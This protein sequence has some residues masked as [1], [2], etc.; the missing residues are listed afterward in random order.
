M[1][2]HGNGGLGTGA[3]EPLEARTLMSL[4][5]VGIKAATASTTEGFGAAKAAIVVIDRSGGNLA[6]PLTVDF[7]L[8]GSATSGDYASISTSAVI[9]AGVKSVRIPVISTDD[10]LA[11]SSEQVSFTLAASDRYTV[12]E[13]RRAATVT[14]VDNEPIVSI[15]RGKDASEGKAG[16]QAGSFTIKRSGKDLTQSIR[17]DL[18]LQSA[19]TAT[20]GVDFVSMPRSVVIPAGQS[21]VSLP[22]TPIQDGRQEATERVWIGLANADRYRLDAKRTAAAVGIAN[23]ARYDLVSA[24]GLDRASQL[25]Y[26]YTID[27]RFTYSDAPADVART[28]GL[29]DISSSRDGSLAFEVTSSSDSDADYLLR[30]F[31][32][33]VGDGGNYLSYLD[34]EDSDLGFADCQFEGLLLTPPLTTGASTARSNF[35]MQFDSGS[36][37]GVID[38]SVRFASGRRVTTPAGAFVGDEISIVLKA[39]GS[40]VSDFDGEESPFS[41]DGTLSL[42]FICVDGLG[43]VHATQSL[44][45]VLQEVGSTTRATIRSSFS[46]V[47]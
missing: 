10:A 3:I 39:R 6:A 14:I 24:L 16:P 42:T 19:S 29:V 44:D 31:S 35:S 4:P 17:V 21:S 9:P 27:S 5:V 8:G 41:F 18:V 32:V 33:D 13:K 15:A 2:R 30:R 45:G 23:V 37:S 28:T 47:S 20:E 38:A 43:I 40:G 12:V 36:A 1:K 11:E 25:S 46:L 26:S 34:T 22:V 7:T